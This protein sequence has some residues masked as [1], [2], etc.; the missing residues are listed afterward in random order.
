MNASGDTLR[1]AF[2]VFKLFRQA[3]GLSPRTIE[4][5]SYIMRTLTHSPIGVAPGT[6]M[7]EIENA[8]LY[9]HV[10]GL[11]FGGHG[12]KP[13]KASSINGHVRALRAFFNWAWKEKYTDEKLLDNLKPPR[14]DYKEITVLNDAEIARLDATAFWPLRGGDPSSD[15]IMLS[16]RA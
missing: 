10:A 16:L 5:Y 11:S 14:P 8:Q 4:W 3:E 1:D 15:V 9:R 13:L 2:D 12:G 6:P 7:R